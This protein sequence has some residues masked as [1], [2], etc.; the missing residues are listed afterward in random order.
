MRHE[1]E[2][3]NIGSK[4]NSLAATDSRLEIERGLQGAIRAIATTRG[5]LDAMKAERD[6]AV[7][8]WRAATSQ[9]LAEEAQKLSDA[10]EAL[11]KAELR[12][13]LVELRA[14]RDGVVLAVA[15]V[16]VGSVLQSGDPFIT[17]VPANAPMEVEVNIIGRDAGFAQRGDPVAIKFDTFPFAQYGMAE[18]SVRTISADSF[19][20]QDEARTRSGSVPTTPGS[21]EPFYRARITIGELAMRNLPENFQVSLGMPVTAEI[22]VGKRTVLD[23]LMG[24]ILPVAMEGMREP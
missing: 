3:Q 15:K 6:G 23:Y 19:T 9:K 8:S 13:H 21:I 20:A 16:S 17:L 1:L 4:L 11:H 2:R 7:Q 24:K 14:D 10:S 5:D 12:R 18:G 22:K